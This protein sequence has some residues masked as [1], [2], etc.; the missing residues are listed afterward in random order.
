M[1]SSE[2]AEANVL[3][4]FIKDSAFSGALHDRTDEQ[5]KDSIN[6]KHGSKHPDLICTFTVQLKY[7][8]L[9]LYIHKTKTRVLPGWMFG[10]FL[11]GQSLI[12]S[13]LVTASCSLSGIFFLSWGRTKNGE[14]KFLSNTFLGAY[15]V[16]PWLPFLLYFLPLD[17]KLVS[18]GKHE[19][20]FLV[21]LD[22]IL[23]FWFP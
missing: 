10:L 5:S 8:V 16:L 4:S 21:V 11:L 14:G 20:A 2:T 6:C 17:D 7:Q 23:S 12:T 13:R 18:K 19:G 3:F 22:Q 1:H 9:A 15:K